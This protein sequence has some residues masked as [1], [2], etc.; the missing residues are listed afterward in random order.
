MY[1]SFIFLPVKTG[2]P[3]TD[4]INHFVPWGKFLRCNNL[5]KKYWNH[6]L[7]EASNRA[8][9]LNMLDKED[10]KEP[11]YPM[12]PNGELDIE[13]LKLKRE[14]EE[15][16]RHEEQMRLEAE[17]KAYEKSFGGRLEKFLTFLGSLIF[18]K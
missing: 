11:Y 17:R 15:K 6:N 13:A 5:I 14:K 16:E 18:S 8:N 4:S 12:L 7:S 2:D 9:I 10:G 3:L 1:S